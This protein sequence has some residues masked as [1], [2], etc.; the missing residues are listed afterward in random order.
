MVEDAPLWA[1]LLI[2][3]ILAFLA[4]YA[5]VLNAGCTAAATGARSRRT[6]LLAPLREVVR[7]LLQ[8]RRTTLAPDA[9][10]WRLGGGTL[11][12]AAGLMLVVVPLGRWSVADV[13]V[14]IV[15]FNAM[16]I[17][18]WAVVW[19]AGWG[20]NTHYGLAGGYRFL[21][22]A[23]AYEFPLMFG[24][25]APAIAAQS[26]RVGD[27]V[28]AQQPLW[29]VVWMPVAFLGFLV[30]VLGFAMWG[31]LAYPVGADIAS[32]IAV[33]VSGADRLVLLA[34][35]YALLAAGAAFSVPLFLAGGAGPLLPGWSW[36]LL[37]TL[38][39]LTAL[40]L[41]ARRLPTLRADRFTE[42]AWLVLMP[43]TLLQL[44]VV[45]LVVI[46]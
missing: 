13:P 18:M 7:L 40:V 27:V 42:V 35:R 11:L 24:I 21:A 12:V 43:L 44:L 20:G 41:A 4:C 32:G 15:W 37:K 5:A 3:P 17:V 8:Q 25:T 2:P 14:G 30:G 23:L 10:V 29:F 22:Q 34:G 46:S 26:L 38:A 1:G 16:D 28:A 9:L 19:L 31:P 39:V 36:S 45:S 33:E 6:V